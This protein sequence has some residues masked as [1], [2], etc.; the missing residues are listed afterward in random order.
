MDC[1][2]FTVLSI[3]LLAACVSAQTATPTAL[4]VDYDQ[5]I[6]PQDLEPGDIK[7]MYVVVTNTG[8]MPAREVRATLPTQGGGIYTQGPSSDAISGAGDW[9]LGTI[10]PG[11]SARVVTSVRVSDKAAIGAHYLTL[12]LTYD[13]SRYDINNRLKI[14][15]E[16]TKWI[17]PV[18]VSSGSLLEMAD[19]EVSTEELRAGDNIQLSLSL[20]N[21][22]EADAFDVKSYLGMPKDGDPTNTQINLDLASAF[23]VLGASEKDIGDI[24]SDSAGTVDLIIHIDEDV[25]SK[26]YTLPIT[27]EYEDKGGEEHVDIFYVGVFVT[28]DRKLT[29]TNFESDPVEIH[30]DDEDVEFTGNIENQGSEQ[31]KNVK[32]TFSPEAPLK[33]ARSYIQTKE[34]GT[35]RGGE[36]TAFTFYAD[37]PEDVKPQQTSVVFEMEYEVNSQPFK[38]Q[39]SYSID[40]LEHP[41]FAL[42]TESEPVVPNG[43]GVARVTVAN[44]GSECDGVTLIVLEKRDQPFDF[45]DKSAYVGDLEGGAEGVASIAFSVKEKATAQPHLVPVEVRC[46]VDDEVLVHSKTVKLMVAEPSSSGLVMTA[47]SLVALVAIAFFAYRKGHQR[48]HEKGK[49][50]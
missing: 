50:N 22:G 29:I 1:R 25:D 19:Y 6:I 13:E 39:I 26:A 3:L 24:T 48:G 27:A 4:V 33:N 21:T 8:G 23:T 37:V 46:T 7:P 12:Y 14:E 36:S 41:S 15:E 40:I 17:I 5:S 35:I 34:V 30:S 16:T 28:G 32:V 45:D 49:G 43:K 31:V 10:S 44:T 9:F 47:F 11:G 2:V 20:R 42:K 38:D 18:E